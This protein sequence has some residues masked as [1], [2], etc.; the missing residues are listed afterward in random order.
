MPPYTKLPTPEGHLNFSYG[1]LSPPNWGIVPF[2]I[3]VSVYANVRVALQ[4]LLQAAT[5][6]QA[7]RLERGLAELFDE[8]IFFRGHSDVTHRILPTRLRGLWQQPA[9]R[10]RFSVAAPPT[11]TFNGIEFPSSTFNSGGEDPRNH[12]GNWFE[13]VGPTR[14]IEDSL[15]EVLAELPRRDALELAALERASQISAVAA[16]DTFR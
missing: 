4:A 2:E 12:W 9:A 15:S 10:E 7:Q 3:E 13:N 14:R 11:V 8:H 16:L 6:I 5:T 1:P